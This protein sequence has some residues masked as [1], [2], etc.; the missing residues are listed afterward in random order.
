MK[1]LQFR[2]IVSVHV[3]EQHYMNNNVCL[4]IEV[5][6]FDLGI[7]LKPLAKEVKNYL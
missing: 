3:H 7:F 4:I 5:K 2:D 6:L 1:G